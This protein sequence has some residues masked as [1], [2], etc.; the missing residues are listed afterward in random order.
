MSVFYS[1]YQYHHWYIFLY[2]FSNIIEAFTLIQLHID[3]IADH[4]CISLKMN[5][6]II[7]ESSGHHMVIMVTDRFNQHFLNGSFVYST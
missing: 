2:L 1:F 4:R 6:N 3:I 5:K 7:A